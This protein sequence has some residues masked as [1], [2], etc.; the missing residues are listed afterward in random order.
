MF[1]KHWSKCSQD[2]VDLDL[3]PNKLYYLQA[4]AWHL[5]GYIGGR[6]G[7]LTQYCSTQQSWL[8][9][10][11]SDRETVGYQCSSRARPAEIIWAGQGRNE[12]PL[13]TDR[14]PRAQ[15]FGHDP[16]IVDCCDRVDIDRVI[17]ALEQ[18]PY[19]DFNLILRNCN[20]MISFL[21]YN[22]K[23]NLRRPM[24]CIGYRDQFYWKKHV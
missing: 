12:I 16:E 15:W 5:K 21:I 13:I 4:Q 7:Y 17:S 3:D 11:L 8:T 2:I 22:L 6:H 9:I 10:E 23:L 1:F 19:K 14:D 18:Y 24:L 20:T